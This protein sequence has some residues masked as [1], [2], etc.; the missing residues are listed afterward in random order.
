MKEWPDSGISIIN[1]RYGPYIKQGDKNYRIPKDM[2]AE[3]LTEEQCKEIVAGS[4]PT[5]HK[6]RRFKKK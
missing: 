3:N 4:A 6:T 5:S 1:G 2:S